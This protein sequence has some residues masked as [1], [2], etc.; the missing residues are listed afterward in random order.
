MLALLALLAFL[1]A[2]L[3]KVIGGHAALVTWLIILGGVIVAVA[4]AGFGPAAPWRRP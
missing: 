3:F 4:A 1:A 2:A